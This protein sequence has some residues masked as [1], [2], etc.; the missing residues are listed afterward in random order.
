MCVCVCLCWIVVKNAET[1]LYDVQMEIHCG[2]SFYLRA[3]FTLFHAFLH[4][5]FPLSISIFDPNFIC[6][7]L[8]TGARKKVNATKIGANCQSTKIRQVNCMRMRVAM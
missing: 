6:L 3:I 4:G 5:Q 2:F 7:T 8:M 1:Y